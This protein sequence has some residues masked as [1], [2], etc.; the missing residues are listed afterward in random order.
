MGT[1]SNWVNHKLNE[2]GTYVD[3]DAVKENAMPSL[4]NQFNLLNFLAEADDLPKLAKSLVGKVGLLRAAIKRRDE[5]SKLLAKKRELIAKLSTASADQILEY[6]LGIAPT[7]G[8]AETLYKNLG[9]PIHRLT[10]AVF[11]IHSEMLAEIRGRERKIAHAKRKAAQGVRGHDIIGS[12]SGVDV[13]GPFLSFQGV[14]FQ[15]R[16]TWSLEIR[17]NAHFT[18]RYATDNMLSDLLDGAGI[19]PDLATLWN[20]LP[21]TFLIDYV[22]PF[23][24][25]LEKSYGGWSWNEVF[26]G[27]SNAVSVSRAT[28]SRKAT[29]S[30][31]VEPLNERNVLPTGNWGIVWKSFI[32]GNG[33][34]NVY[35]RWIPDAPELDGIDVKHEKK[36][37]TVDRQ[38]LNAG[39]LATGPVIA[40]ARKRRM[41]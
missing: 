28:I 20:A 16:V 18:G 9:A 24:K 40:A 5:A 13:L 39:A 41:L 12:P 8:D 11:D 15:L 38:W 4:R 34:F 2:W 23:G 17:A 26:N 21:F 19:Y 36:Q 6:N 10:E 27:G 7:I 29:C 35:E 1:I 22:F 33:Q 14:R 31:F 37:E 3:W 32:P 30:F 25:Y